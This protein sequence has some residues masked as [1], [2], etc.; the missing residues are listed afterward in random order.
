[1]KYEKYTLTLLGIL[2]KRLRL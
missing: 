1:L 2:S